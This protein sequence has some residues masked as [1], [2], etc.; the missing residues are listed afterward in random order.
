MSFLEFLARL[1][2]APAPVS[3]A[4]KSG[5][6]VLA[7]GEPSIIGQS[8]RFGICLAHVLRHEG[9]YVDDPRDPGGATNMGITIGTLSDWLGRPATKDEVRNLPR[10]IAEA[11]YHKRYWLPVLG[12]ALGPGVDLAVFDYAVNSG[13]GRAIRSLQRAVGAQPDG[14]M[15]PA[16]LA[17]LA[18]RDRS[19]LVQ[20]ICDR[21]I[22]FFQSLDTFDA[23]GRGWMR[24]VSEVEDA[25]LTA[26]P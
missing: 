12:D 23:F 9:G 20:D 22:A 25:A 21:R 18:G 24:R 11:I 13:P 26:R 7:V 6:P 19:A 1:F 3:E 16:T 2:R 5:V 17:A 8:E 10:D 14:V 4:P 15:G